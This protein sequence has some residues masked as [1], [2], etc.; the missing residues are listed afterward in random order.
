MNNSYMPD[1]D[2]I[3]TIIDIYF[4]NI[5]LDMSEETKSKV[6][7]IIISDIYLRC[8]MYGHLFP[9]GIIQNSDNYNSNYPIKPVNGR[10]SI[11][12]FLL[13]KLMFDLREIS[14]SGAMKSNGGEYSAIPKS[15]NINITELGKAYD[16]SQTLKRKTDFAQIKSR[17]IAKT[18]HHELG[19]ALKTVYTGGYKSFGNNL[20]QD[21]NYLNLLE[22]LKLSKYGNRIIDK[23]QLIDDVSITKNVGLTISTNVNNNTFSY[24]DQYKKVAGYDYLDEMVN[25]DE[26][27]ELNKCNEVQSTYQIL[28]NGQKTDNYINVYNHTSGY[29]SFTGYGRCLRILLG[30]RNSFIAQYGS[31]GFIFKQFDQEYKDI[32]NEVFGNDK[33]PLTNICNSLYYIKNSKELEA[34]EK[35]DLFMAKAYERKVQ[36]LLSNNYTQGNL[37]E[38]I[39]G[40]DSML[41]RMSKNNNKTLAHEKILNDLKNNLLDIYN[42]TNSSGITM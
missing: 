36:N 26:A 21:S 33:T 14:F 29:R 15:L 25:E 42:K 16:E 13:N 5:E 17:G 10:Y 39:N 32:S 18:I 40:I 12:D 11:E 8:R 2:K 31:P 9:N 1:K 22:E 3:Q 37:L 38:L 34:Y 6:K 23:N 7:S 24:M 19:H 28:S 41:D 4:N 27:L 20:K 35:M 30:E